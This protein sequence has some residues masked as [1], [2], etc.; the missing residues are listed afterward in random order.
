MVFLALNGVAL[1][2]PR[3]TPDGW[4]YLDAG[5]SIF[6]AIAGTIY[7]YRK[8]GGA[9]GDHFMQR[10]FVI[11][12][13]VAM[14]WFAWVVPAIFFYYV[15]LSDFGVEGE[16]ASW[17]EAAFFAA[18]ETILY[19]RIGHHVADLRRRSAGRECEAH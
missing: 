8:N 17:H 15:A 19:W 12:W 16:P 9:A 7:I 11:G 3:T 4:N 2:V 1:L 6:L 14:R 10:Y 5:C 13:V 18:C